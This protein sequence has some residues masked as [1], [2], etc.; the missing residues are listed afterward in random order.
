MS[1]KPG[2]AEEQSDYQSYLLRL[3]RV[4]EGEEG[5]SLS[6]ESAHTGERRGFA[7]L[8]AMLDFLRQRIAPRPSACAEREGERESERR[9]ERG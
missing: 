9:E 6:L 5:W 8:E 4:D 2:C 7:D 3:W 1:E